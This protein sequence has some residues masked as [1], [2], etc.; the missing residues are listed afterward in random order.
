VDITVL[1]FSWL[2]QNHSQVLSGSKGDCSSLPCSGTFPSEHRSQILKT[3]QK[4]TRKEQGHSWHRHTGPQH[5]PCSCSPTTQP[6]PSF[7]A[8]DPSCP[9]PQRSRCSPPLLSPGNTP[10]GLSCPVP[11]PF[12]RGDS[13][14]LWKAHSPS[15][16]WR[17]N[18]FFLAVLVFFYC[19]YS[20]GVRIKEKKRK[21]GV[22]DACARHQ[23]PLVGKAS[24]AAAST[25][26]SD[27]GLRVLG[28]GVSVLTWVG[29]PGRIRPSGLP[30]SKYKNQSNRQHLSTGRMLAVHAHL[31]NIASINTLG[32]NSP[33]LTTP[34]LCSA[35]PS[36]NRNYV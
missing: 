3:S 22:G 36:T 29:K 2:K 35:H 9:A 25:P 30:P 16:I 15:R 24:A 28:R 21:A 13:Q 32:P 26:T 12:S 31:W 8:Q 18:H 27:P 20:F 17:G 1:C 7:S 4:P 6:V 23:Q 34:H 5:Q 33:P 11:A 19:C 14:H 10:G